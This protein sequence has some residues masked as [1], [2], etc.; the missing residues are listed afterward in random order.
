L[1]EPVTELRVIEDKLC[2]RL[3]AAA[4]IERL[5]RKI[6]GSRRVTGYSV[7]IEYRRLYSGRMGDDTP[8]E[9]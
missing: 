6:Y 1:A 5:A 8:G 4:L 7:L 9:A 3:F 2:A